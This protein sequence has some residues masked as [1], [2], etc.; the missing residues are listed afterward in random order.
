[1][2]PA[3]IQAAVTASQVV[4][5]DETSVRAAGK[6]WWERVFGT[7]RPGVWVSDAL[8]SQ[9]G[10]ADDWQMCL[11]QYRGWPSIV[12]GPVSWL[13]QY[14]ADLDRRPDRI[15][16]AVPQGHAHLFVFV[17]DR[18]V[19]ATNNASERHLRPSLGSFDVLVSI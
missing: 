6:T 18:D 10:H 16:T 4:C 3:P 15:M 17:T 2:L 9:R 1:M 13:A 14:R 19:P 7:V 5:C 12:A 8:G 11:A